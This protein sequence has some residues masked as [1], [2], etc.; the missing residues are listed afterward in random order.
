MNDRPINGGDDNVVPIGKKPD[1]LADVQAKDNERT[2]ELLVTFSQLVIKSF[3]GKPPLLPGAIVATLEIQG[4]QL[5]SLIDMIVNNKPTTADEFNKLM[6]VRLKANIQAI[7]SR[8]VILA[9]S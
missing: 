1:T 3:E 4:M 5:E 8:P 7:R 9:P 6:R 2:A